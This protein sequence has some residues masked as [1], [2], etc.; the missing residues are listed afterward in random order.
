MIAAFESMLFRPD[1]NSRDQR[2]YRTEAEAIAGHAELLRTL[3]P[4]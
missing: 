2:R 3:R 1:G 4:G